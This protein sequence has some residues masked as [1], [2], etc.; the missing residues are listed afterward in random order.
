[1]GGGNS[2]TKVAPHQG[3]STAEAIKYNLDALG[4]GQYAK[5]FIDLGYDDI[6]LKQIIDVRH[7]LAQII[8]II[9]R[10]PFS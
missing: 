8:S 9:V 4:L 10:P 1:M 7:T 6:E 5:A 3:A 2:K